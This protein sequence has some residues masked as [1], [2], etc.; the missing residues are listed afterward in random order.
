MV[1]RKGEAD[2]KEEVERRREAENGT[3]RNEERVIGAELCRQHRVSDVMYYKSG[4]GYFSRADW[5]G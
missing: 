4:G 1:L 5:A 2:G 3:G